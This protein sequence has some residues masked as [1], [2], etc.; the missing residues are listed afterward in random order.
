M[1]KINPTLSIRSNTRKCVAAE[2]ESPIPLQSAMYAARHI[3]HFGSIARIAPGMIQPK[4]STYRR[5]DVRGLE[6][7]QQ[8]SVFIDTLRGC[9]LIDCTSARWLGVA[10][11]GFHASP[12]PVHVPRPSPRRQAV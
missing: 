7:S 8:R 4:T 10:P 2:S 5:A 1:N 3:G 9:C 12:C 6:F 11:V